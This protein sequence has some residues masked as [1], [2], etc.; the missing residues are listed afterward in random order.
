MKVKILILFLVIF[1]SMTFFTL[2]QNSDKYPNYPNVQQIFNNLAQ[3]KLE[4]LRVVLIADSTENQ[5]VIGGYVK[6]TSL[7]GDSLIPSGCT[8]W[9]TATLIPTD[10]IYVSSSSSFPLNNIALVTPGQVYSLSKT[11]ILAIPKLYY[12]LVGTYTNKNVQLF[13]GGF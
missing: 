5:T 12:K 8:Q 10:S 13:Y 7:A 2:A 3:K 6:A 4:V 9:W 1:F 11:S